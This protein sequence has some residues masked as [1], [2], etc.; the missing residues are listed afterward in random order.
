MK[1][2]QESFKK[3]KT[4]LCSEPV[5]KIFDL[6][7][8]KEIN[9][10]ENI[11]VIEAVLKQKDKYGNNKSIPYFSKKLSEVH[12]KKKAIFLSV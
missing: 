12:K 7:L 6:D 2:C 5:L 8:P 10:D 1:E 3:I 11:K 4:L 9:T